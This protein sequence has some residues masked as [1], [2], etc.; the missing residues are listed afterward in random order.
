MRNE[1]ELP[2]TL[3]IVL[4]V[5]ILTESHV[6]AYAC[7]AA[8]AGLYIVPVIATLIDSFRGHED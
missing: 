8:I 7:L 5:A 4:A 1:L 3:L 6:A 2:V